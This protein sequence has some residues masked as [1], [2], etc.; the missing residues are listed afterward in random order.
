MSDRIKALA[1]FVGTI[2]GVG[3]FGLPWVGAK[4]GFLALIFYFLLLSTVVIIV[5]LMFGEV[6]LG[7]KGIHRLPG[8]VKEYLGEN[9]KNFSLFN[10]CLGLFGAQL[11]YLIV[12]GE[13][14]RS[15]FSSYLGGNNLIYTLVFFALGS[16][17]IFRGIKS[18]S[19]CEFLILI[20]FFFVI[21]F[22]LI[23]AFPFI[24]IKNFS[25]INF[26]FLAYPYGIILFSLWGSAI[27]PEIKEI[28]KGR[29]KDLRKVIIFGI[30]ISGLV[31]LVFSFA[32]IG[33]SGNLTSKEAFSGLVPFLGTNIV[34]F[35]VVFGLF[36]SFSSFLTLG[37]TLKKIFF[38]DLSLSSNRS[39]LLATFLPLV[40]FLL[41]L[42]Q[43]IDVI[44]FTGA[45]SLGCEGLIIVLLYKRFLERK[46]AKKMNAFYYLLPLFFVLGIFVEIFYFLTR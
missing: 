13:F 12:G 40:L 41:G 15:L 14:L 32:V 38:Y 46:G 22:F 24:T 20:F 35:G 25:G 6:C 10:T 33:V 27:I 18:I 42:R 26:R 37:L 43:F 1:V 4:S 19:F 5:H 36:A 21:V 29:H 34:R 3:V 8:Y 7:T 45:L 39:F 28:L 11:A 44:S 16:Y 2:I 17:L 31:Y 9:W 30:L 23:K